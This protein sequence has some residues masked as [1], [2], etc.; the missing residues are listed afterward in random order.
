MNIREKYDLEITLLY[1]LLYMGA[2]SLL[3]AGLFTGI[4]V[5]IPALIEYLI[6]G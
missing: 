1:F 6:F 4:I 2:G 5:G 3:I